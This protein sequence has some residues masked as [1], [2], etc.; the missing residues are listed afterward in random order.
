MKVF[1]CILHLYHRKILSPKSYSMCCNRV[2][3]KCLY[4]ST[5]RETT[6]TYA[7][8]LPSCRCNTV[9][10]NYFVPVGDVQQ[11]NAINWSLADVH[12]LLA[13]VHILLADEVVKTSDVLMYPFLA[14]TKQC[15]PQKHF[16]DFTVCSILLLSTYSSSVDLTIRFEKLL[17]W[18][19]YRLPS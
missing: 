17:F 10:T 6:S 12:I 5:D 1:I 16:H 14:K 19:F 9:H 11:P 4:I 7:Q 13:D 18:D 15:L 3:L 2:W 8:Q